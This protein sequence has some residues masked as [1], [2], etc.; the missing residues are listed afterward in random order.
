MSTSVRAVGVSHSGKS[1]PRGETIEEGTHDELLAA[2]GH[3]AELHNTYFRHQ[4]LEYIERF[5][6]VVADS[7][8]AAPAD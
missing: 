8:G 6:D 1:H 2:G 4:L 3:C 7:I 5:S